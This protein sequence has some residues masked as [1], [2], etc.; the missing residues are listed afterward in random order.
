[1]YVSQVEEA[2]DADYDLVIRQGQYWI[3]QPNDKRPLVAPIPENPA[4]AYTSENAH[5]VVL[6]LEHIARW[7][8]ILQLST[9]QTDV[10]MEISVLSGREET[11]LSGDE[12]IASEMRLEYT[13][14]NDEWVSPTIQIKLTNNSNKALYCNVLDLA[15]SYSISSNLLDEYQASSFKI[16][17]KDSEKNNTLIRA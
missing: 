1:L 13:Y 15:E 10:E 16:P 14:E 3:T 4:E 9:P 2:K 6:R 11:S 8:N 7:T 12:K 5:Q 17:P